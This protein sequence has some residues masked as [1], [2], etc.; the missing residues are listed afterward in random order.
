MGFLE[1]VFDFIANLS[2]MMPDINFKFYFI[3]VVGVLLGIFIICCIAFLDSRMFRLQ[4]ACKKISKFLNEVECVDDDNAGIF[5]EKCFT[6]VPQSLR[7]AWVEYSGVRFGYPSEIISDKNVFDKELDKTGDIRAKIFLG[8][9]LFVL[10]FFA[11]WGY[12][13]L[14][15]NE[16]GVIQLVGLIILAVCYIGLVVINKKII[17]KSLDIFETTQEE[18]D[19][20]VDMQIEKDFATDSSPLVELASLVDE[21]IG[22]N[23]EKEIIEQENETPIESLIRSQMNDASNSEEEI[24]EEKDNVD[25]FTLAEMEDVSSSETKEAINAIDNDIEF[26]PLGMGEDE[27]SIKTT[28]LDSNE[29]SEK[30]I[31][32][33]K[34]DVSM[35]GK[36]ETLFNAL[37]YNYDV[38]DSERKDWIETA[39]GEVKEKEEPIA[40]VEETSEVNIDM[41][42]NIINTDDSGSKESKYA[43][44]LS[45]MD[46]ITNAN[47]SQQMKDQIISLLEEVVGKKS[48]KK[49][50]AKVIKECIDKLKK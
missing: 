48:T 22:R 35:H 4:I 13:K 2:T 25:L 14:E 5:T 30:S 43:K 39:V 50:D 27:V 45:L 7:D 26:K 36:S 10:A 32:E 29:E 8:I 44:L 11:F 21:I 31:S 23:T 49:A 20:K 6:K 9:G 42:E 12:G 34:V 17:K 19:A 15:K 47:V 40:T 24:N 28:M 3:V 1:K 18:L 16:I 37:N 46:Y 38:K 33:D 41:I